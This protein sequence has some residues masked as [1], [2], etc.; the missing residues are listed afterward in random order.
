MD[1]FKANHLSMNSNKTVG[2]LF[3][4]NKSSIKELHIAETNITFVDSTKFL[5]VWLDCKLNWHEHISRVG[6]KIRK[7]LNLLK[8]GRN[9][10]DI[11]SKRIAYFSQIQSHLTYGLSVWGHMSSTTA[12]HRLQKLQNESVALINSRKAD[13]NNCKKLKILKLDQ[14]L[15]LENCKFG[16]KLL[17]H[18]LLECIGELVCSDQTGRSLQKIHKY[19]RNRNLLNKPLAKNKH[20]KNCIIYKGTSLLEPNLKAETKDRPCLQSFT[21][22]C[23]KLLLEM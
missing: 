22:A 2:M 6:Q 20:Y 11:H 5:G 19:T 16:Y 18:D 13:L 1:W 17:H 14:L 8:L 10:L 4:K 3:S 21:N 7:N 23:K 15:S 9:F 12:L